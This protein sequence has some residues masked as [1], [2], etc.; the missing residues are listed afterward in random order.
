MNLPTAKDN[1]TAALA[2]LWLVMEL[3]TDGYS[4]ATLMWLNRRGTNPGGFLWLA[5]LLNCRPS[6][7]EQQIYDAANGS[8][9]QRQK[10]RRRIQKFLKTC[11]E[12]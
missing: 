11:D 2:A 9:D 3:A 1:R 4:A 10:L 12:T 5:G 6:I 7:L 8:A